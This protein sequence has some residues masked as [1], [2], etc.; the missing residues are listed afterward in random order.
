MNV[1]IIISQM[2][3]VFS[4]TQLLFRKEVYQVLVRRAV[5]DDEMAQ[6]DVEVVLLFLALDAR[7]NASVMMQW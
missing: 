1:L 3:S 2:K 7:L 4:D 5:K 6:S